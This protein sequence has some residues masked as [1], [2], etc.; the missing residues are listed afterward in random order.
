MEQ[1]IA[2][3]KSQCDSRVS[4][5]ESELAEARSAADSAAPIQDEQELE[6]LQHENAE[7]QQKVTV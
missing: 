3:M 5:L 1:A 4:K 7:L 2:A 6:R